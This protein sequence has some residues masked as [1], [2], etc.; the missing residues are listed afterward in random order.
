MIQLSI[1]MII[2]TIVITT[3]TITI[4]RLNKS[5]ADLKKSSIASESYLEPLN[6][7]QL[8]F[9]P[10]PLA[11]NRIQYDTNEVVK[12]QV[13]NQ[14]KLSN[15]YFNLAD[16]N[17]F[18]QLY[19]P[20]TIDQKVANL[21]GNIDWNYLNTHSLSTVFWLNNN[22][23]QND[24]DAN[25]YHDLVFDNI[26][27]KTKLVGIQKLDSGRILFKTPSLKTGLLKYEP[28]LK[29]NMGVAQTNANFLTFYQFDKSLPFGLKNFIQNPMVI[30]NIDINEQKII[31]SPSY[32]EFDYRVFNSFHDTWTKVIEF[33][34]NNTISSNYVAVPL[35]IDLKQS[36]DEYVFFA[37]YLR[38]QKPDLN[39]INENNI[40]YEY[41]IPIADREQMYYDLFKNYLFIPQ[42]LADDP[43]QFNRI[44]D[45][46]AN[47]KSLLNTKI[48]E[49]TR[50]FYE[51]SRQ[52]FLANERQ[53]N[54][55]QSQLSQN[56]EQ[57]KLK[58]NDQNLLQQKRLLE[59]QIN[60]YRNNNF[61]YKYLQSKSFIQTLDDYEVFYKKHE[62]G[63]FNDSKSD[64]NFIVV[65]TSQPTYKKGQVV[66]DELRINNIV[67]VNPKLKDS[68]KF[69][70]KYERVYFHK[71]LP[72]F[73]NF[74]TLFLNYKA[75]L[76]YLL[77]TYNNDSSQDASIPPAERD[78]TSYI[79]PGIIYKYNL[80]D[81]FRIIYENGDWLTSSEYQQEA[82]HFSYDLYDQFIYQPNKNFTIPV[83]INS[84]NKQD[85]LIA[86]YRE[87]NTQ[88]VFN[89]PAYYLNEDSVFVMTNDQYR[90]QAKTL[91]LENIIVKGSK[92][93]KN[94]LALRKAKRFYDLDYDVFS[95]VNDLQALI[96][97][98]ET[99]PLKLKNLQNAIN[100]FIRLFIFHNFQ[101]NGDSYLIESVVQKSNDI[102]LPFNINIFE[103][104]SDLA[105]VSSAYLQAHNKDSNNPKK[106]GDLQTY[107][108]AQ[109]MVYKKNDNQPPFY[110]INGL[111]IAKDYDSW[112]RYVVPDENKIEINNQY[113]YILDGV[114]SA[115]FLFPAINADDILI[116]PSKSA[117]LYVN[118]GGFDKLKAYNS[119]VDILSYYTLKSDTKPF[120]YFKRSQLFEK[121][122]K[123]FD[124]SHKAKIYTKKE[125][126]KTFPLYAKRVG[127]LDRLTYIVL[128]IAIVL[129]SL[130]MILGMYFV[131]TSLRNL[132][133]K[134]QI[135]FATLLA[136][137]QSKFK[138]WASFLPFYVLPPIITVLIAYPIAFFLQP[139][140]MSLFSPY[141]FISL[142]TNFVSVGWIFALLG[143]LAAI[144]AVIS[145]IAILKILSKPVAETMKGDPG[146]KL[147]KLM[148]SSRKILSKF[149]ASAVLRSTYVLSNI[150][151]MSILMIISSSFTIT[152]TVLATTKNNFVS[153]AIHTNK[154]R[155]YQYAVDLYSPTNQGGLYYTS[156]YHL[157]GT[158]TKNAPMKPIVQQVLL[159]AK[160]INYAYEPVD[161]IYHDQN[162]KQ[163]IIKSVINHDGFIPFDYLSLPDGNVYNFEQIRLH[164]RPQTKIISFEQIN[165][166]WQVID[167]TKLGYFIFENHHQYIQVKK[168]NQ[169]PNLTLVYQHNEKTLQLE[170]VK[171]DSK[172][173]YFDVSPLQ[174]TLGLYVLKGLYKNEEL[175]YKPELFANNLLTLDY[176]KH[177]YFFYDHNTRLPFIYFNHL[178]SDLEDQNLI[179]YLRYNNITSQQLTSKVVNNQ[180]IFDLSHLEYL[181]EPQ[182]NSTN[183]Y[184]I[185]YLASD[186]KVIY[187]QDKQNLSDNIHYYNN[188]LYLSNITDIHNVQFD[189]MNTNRKINVEISAIPLCNPNHKNNAICTKP[190]E[191]KQ[192]QIL[193]NFLRPGIVQINYQHL[194]TNHI[195]EI[196][197]IAYQDQQ[198]NLYLNNLDQ[199]YKY[200]V[201]TLPYST[202]AYN[203]AMRVI[204]SV[205]D[206]NGPITF[207]P[208]LSNTYFP[209]PSTQPEI[210]ENIEFL[211]SKIITKIALDG[212]IQV[213]TGQFPIQFNPWVFAKTFLPTQV[214]G[215]A[216]A[217]SQSLLEAAFREFGYKFDTNKQKVNQLFDVPDLNNPQIVHK[218]FSLWTV[219]GKPPL[220][221]NDP[222]NFFIKK[223]GV[224]QFN[225]ADNIGT[226]KGAAQF[227]PEFVRL[228]TQI[229]T[230][231][232]LNHKQ[233]KIALKTVNFDSNE[234][235]Q[236]YTY[237]TG[238]LLINKKPSKAKILGINYEQNLDEKTKQLTFYDDQQKDL[239]NL[240][241]NDDINQQAYPLLINAVVAKKYQLRVGDEVNF[242][243][244]NHMRRFTDQ[245]NNHKKDYQT[246]FKV[247]G[248]VD[249]HMDEQFYINQKIANELIGF[250]AY[251]NQKGYER[252][253]EISS[254]RLFNGFFT[255]ETE[256]LFFYNIASF[257]S[258]SGLTPALGNWPIN[259]INFNDE[260]SS[261]AIFYMMLLSWAKINEIISDDP[262]YN[263]VDFS[264]LNMKKLALKIREIFGQQVVVP[265]FVGVDANQENTIL[266][267]TIDYTIFNIFLIVMLSLLP[268]L[269]IIIIVIASTLA[270]ESQ[271]SIAMMKV[272]GTNNFRNVHNFMFVYPIVWI[273]NIIFSIPLAFGVIEL[274]KLAIFNAFN[275]IISPII[276]WWIFILTF[277]LVGM[278]LIGA[279]LL[280]YYKTKNLNLALALAENKE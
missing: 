63:I 99:S 214:S 74:D 53:L 193:G 131:G 32:R 228:I 31:Q 60:N 203:N 213:D 180:V 260:F 218:Q 152:A 155:S 85:E 35:H 217:N 276:P 212:N 279:W 113:F 208:I 41:E 105:Y 255:K 185:Q 242:D 115:E 112:L 83:Q 148:M 240:I 199:I 69:N 55:V 169:T 204:N 30:K 70:K 274:Y 51:Y 46:I 226:K 25:S 2:S 248:I 175:V 197:K 196:K 16:Q 82:D 219:T 232:K 151:R 120:E 56:K 269:F 4:Q 210:F 65:N 47:A 161:I 33:L 272:L 50:V 265:S 173:V 136:Q 39:Q 76:Q 8:V 58:P 220:S 170:P 184:R 141:W 118:Q 262:N 22:Q 57:L 176:Q 257:Y 130:I 174:Q 137:G 129:V 142:P 233:Y 266:A 236:T 87:P 171:Q 45:M 252:G 147:N 159:D 275:I 270:N 256:P 42:E 145:A 90:N 157:I 125:A 194:L 78:Y 13:F 92:D 101:I 140:I 28:Y 27:Q 268:T 202:I 6:H 10:I 249:T 186:A 102:Q 72:T 44:Q 206:K 149:G 198:I 95:Q 222:D 81:F 271:K 182:L 168:P 98:A 205:D 133:K 20:H 54:Y 178:P 237:L 107:L 221:E 52:K 127:F 247:V 207:G 91:Q 261:S 68:L 209:S 138:I 154:Q 100:G 267:K 150:V 190:S 231:K 119:S 179:L 9:E 3:T 116:D 253:Y 12:L 224:W 114:D 167:K 163:F 139:Y 200:G 251:K 109:K 250:N 18:K 15:N 110:E 162:E 135:M 234:Q 93:Q 195:S 77:T 64:T 37:N 280:T 243:I 24:D 244:N 126:I 108:E 59:A 75:F 245:F 223:D 254:E 278:I 29:L 43:K 106:P 94:H 40:L 264:Q 36:S 7:D 14:A 172:F 80:L 246:R 187:S 216:E 73:A 189:Y 238:H 181:N 97:W 160:I 71:S 49:E 277:G 117:V 158:A 88:Q 86:V 235:M 215:K 62:S 11:S 111:K 124:A 229:L 104:T 192:Q 17:A 191:P 48:K 122:K 188:S 123:D 166:D 165:P 156:P 67:T 211:D 5:Q 258:P 143:G 34:E 239:L 177:G 26:N 144:L 61:V 259:D 230:S 146:F 128:T 134:K 183:T 153:S 23:S 89:F 241:K 19:W 21:D 164:K 79:T 103:K 227:R 96:K 263:P 38:H 225:L 66:K 273:I 121:L 201:N 84:F 1:L 132:I